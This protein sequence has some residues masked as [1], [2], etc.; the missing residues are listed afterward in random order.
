MNIVT[1]E[2]WDAREPRKV[3]KTVAH[4][5]FL[6]HTVG[7]LSD[8]YAY[9]RSMQNWHMDGRNFWD[10]GYN[11]V[12]D[13]VTLTVFEGRGWGVRPAAQSNHNDNTWA[14]AIMGHFSEG[15]LKPSQDVIDLTLELITYGRLHGYLPV[16]G[17]VR[18]HYEVQ[19]KD[20][21]GANLK[22]W[23]PYLNGQQEPGQEQEEDV[24]ELI[25]GIQ[26]ALNAGGFNGANG[27]PL[28]VDGILG[29][30]T[31]YALNTQASAAMSG[32]AA[33]KNYPRGDAI[34]ATAIEVV[35]ESSIVP[36]A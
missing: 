16:N 18:G 14:V 7:S 30:N 12:I 26:L 23:L 2:E 29:V 1:R 36:P 27:Q 6:H 32:L 3:V 9:M 11:H 24:T 5:M 28:T 4:E 10:I 21:P 8:P 13:P 31:Q 15:K 17:P 35:N 19:D 25:K 34:R 20:C 33:Y 22:V